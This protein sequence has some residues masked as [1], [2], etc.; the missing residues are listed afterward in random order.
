[1]SFRPLSF[2]RCVVR[3][4]VQR[5]W[6]LFHSL[7]ETKASKMNIE[8]LRQP[9]MDVAAGESFPDRNQEVPA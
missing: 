8:G 6:W 4:S 7:A 9:E 3:R 5:E 2:A 1:M